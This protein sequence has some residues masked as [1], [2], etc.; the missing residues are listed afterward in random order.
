MLYGKSNRTCYV[1]WTQEYINIYEKV[2]KTHQL[3]MMI[4]GN[5]M[6]LVLLA[7]T[8]WHRL[9]MMICDGLFAFEILLTKQDI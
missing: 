3:G 4:D 7:T 9:N 5:N 6:S 8:T 2:V 1:H